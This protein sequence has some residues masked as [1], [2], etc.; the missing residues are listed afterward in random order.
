MDTTQQQS[1]LKHLIAKGKD[2][3]YLTYAEVN[4]HLP[5]GIVD[6]EQIEDIISMINDMGIAVHEVPPDADELLL[7]DN[8]VNSDDDDAAEEAVSAL[9][10]LDAEF[11]RTTDPVRMY[12][13][14]MGTVDL[15]TREGEIR[16]AKRIE[17][18]LN[19]ALRALAAYPT[20]IETLQDAFAL[21]EAG[22]CKLTDILTGFIDPTQTEAAIPQPKA[23]QASS[24][25]SDDDDDDEEE[26]EVDTGPDPEEAKARFAKIKRTASRLRTAVK[27]DG[28]SAAAALKIR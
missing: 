11:G 6:P 10:T 15:L 4:D 9:A 21:Y 27:K 5:D 13:R 14:E 1:Q 28:H 24:D 20:T 18:G 26:E 7:T 25:D 2:Q 8:A 22:E 23:A 3:G 17:Q 16:I 19:Q 12:M